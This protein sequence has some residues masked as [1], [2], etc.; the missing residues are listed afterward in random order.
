MGVLLSRAQAVQRHNLERGNLLGI[1]KR[2]RQCRKGNL[3]ASHLKRVAVVTCGK[4]WVRASR[5][6]RA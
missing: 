5:E 2:R 4:V 3:V 1:V 6:A